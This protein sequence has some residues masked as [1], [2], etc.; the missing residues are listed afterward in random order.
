MMVPPFDDPYS[1]CGAQTYLES[2]GDELDDCPYRFSEGKHLGGCGHGDAPKGTDCKGGCFT[3]IENSE[4][5]R[6][7]NSG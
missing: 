6:F 3:N 4:C 7:T 5:P 1:Y 2:Y